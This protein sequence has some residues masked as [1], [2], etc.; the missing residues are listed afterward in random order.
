MINVYKKKQHNPSSKKKKRGKNEKTYLVPYP[1]TGAKYRWDGMLFNGFS[2]FLYR[3]AEFHLVLHF[4]LRKAPNNNNSN[5]YELG[6]DYIIHD[7]QRVP[8]HIIATVNEKM[9]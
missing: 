5:T 9:P 8:L 4:V 1:N 7:T 2:T 3:L 6:I